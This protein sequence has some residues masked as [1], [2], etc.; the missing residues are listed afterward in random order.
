MIEDKVNEISKLSE[1]KDK[2]TKIIL[3]FF[4][5]FLC[6]GL[7]NAFGNFVIYYKQTDGSVVFIGIIISILFIVGFLIASIYIYIVYFKKESIMGD[8]IKGFDK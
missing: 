4:I 6:F 5:I 8:H 3:I 1:K 2:T 7:V